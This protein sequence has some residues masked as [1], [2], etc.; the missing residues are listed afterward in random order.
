MAPQLNSPGEYVLI[1]TKDELERYQR[2]RNPSEMV[3]L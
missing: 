1:R 3:L 2:I